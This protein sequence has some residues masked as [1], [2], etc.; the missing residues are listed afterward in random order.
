[1]PSKG[2]PSVPAAKG[3]A[4]NKHKVDGQNDLLEDSIFQWDSDQLADMLH[5]ALPEIKETSQPNE[6][7]DLVAKRAREN[8]IKGKD[9]ILL[10]TALSAPGAKP[11]VELN[12]YKKLFDGTDAL[13]RRA[14]TAVRR[15]GDFYKM[16]MQKIR[17]A[18]SSVAI[19]E[20]LA[21]I[22]SP[23]MI[24][25]DKRLP[26]FDSFYPKGKAWCIECGVPTPQVY[27]SKCCRPGEGI[28]AVHGWSVAPEGWMRFALKVDGVEEEE[29][30]NWH[31]A[32]HG[33]AGVNVK[34][35]I[36]KGLI[37]D[38]DQA[39]Q[40]GG[41]AKHIYVSP[42]IEYCSHYVYTSAGDQ[43]VKNGHNQEGPSLIDWDALSKAGIFDETGKFA[44]Y[45]FEVRV[46]PGAYEIQGNTLHKSL[47]ENWF[48]EFDTHCNSRNLEWLIDKSEDLVVTGVM[49]R[50]LPCGPKEWVTS[51]VQAMKK[52]VGWDEAA[53]KP[54]RPRN[55]GGAGPGEQA[56]WEYNGG[57]HTLDR[58]GDAQWIRYETSVSQV[59]EGAY[60]SYQRFVFIGK[61]AGADGPAYF[62]D[63]GDLCDPQIE[64][65]PE[66]RR[67]DAD[68]EQAWRRR[69]VRR[70]KPTEGGGG[71]GGGGKKGGWFFS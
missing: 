21:S 24:P 4:A 35:I 18:N 60:Q 13:F 2:K 57:D 70:V 46:R 12:L 51:R 34:S 19:N 69:A 23:S 45:V 58:S 48:I 61:P 32:Y 36:Q 33:T 20:T 43:E 7:K 50:E 71:D 63:F 11:L 47:W 49:V 27:E 15:P 16:I 40:H 62:I 26:A 30:T 6:L 1:L 28:T 39:G 29:W 55:H 52:M 14:Q 10:L 25:E 54:T 44:Q 68:K 38:P 17:L 67:A 53:K 8:K 37:I 65:G 42:S 9:I 41:T 22:F 64:E 31:K 59:I 66:Q 3:G 56:A 5:T